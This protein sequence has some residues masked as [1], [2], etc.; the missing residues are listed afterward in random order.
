MFVD[1]KIEEWERIIVPTEFEEKFKTK[2]L[3]H[4]ITD[5]LKAFAFLLD[6]IELVQERLP[7]TKAIVAPRYN[8]G[9][10]TFQVYDNNHNILFSNDNEPNA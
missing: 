6:N 10:A 1:I 2:I 3:N 5:A 4:E 7:D 9:E 8:C